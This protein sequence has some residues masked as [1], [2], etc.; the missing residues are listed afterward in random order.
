LQRIILLLPA[1]SPPKEKPAGVNRRRSGKVLAIP[2]PN[3]PEPALIPRE[4]LILEHVMKQ[5]PHF[6]TSEAAQREAV[7]IR[8]MIGDIDRL[9]RLLDCNIAIQ[10][11]CVGISDRTDVAYP[12]LARAMATRRDNLKDTITA[13]EKRLPAL[14]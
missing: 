1:A 6:D 14:D 5:Q 11:E 4:R 12:V 9:A 7:K 3:C 2:S 8:K 13:L 10:E